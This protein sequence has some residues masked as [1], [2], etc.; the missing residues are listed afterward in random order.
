MSTVGTLYDETIKFGLA[1]LQ[2]S[3]L[4]SAAVQY[5]TFALP[6]GFSTFLFDLCNLRPGTDNQ[7]L[8]VQVSMDNGAT[9][10]TDAAYYWTRFYVTSHGVSPSG[11]VVNAVGGAETS[12]QIS[13]VTSNTVGGDVAGELVYHRGNANVAPFTWH[14]CSLT[15]SLGSN[16]VRGAG[17]YWVSGTVNTVR[18]FFAVGNVVG[19]RVNLF[20]FRPGT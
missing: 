14:T 9:W 16:A 2:S 10:K 19:G 4:I 20:C 15:P 5:V 13:G 11:G 18:L 12:L 3:S 1:R 7:T 8:H 6:T 17:T